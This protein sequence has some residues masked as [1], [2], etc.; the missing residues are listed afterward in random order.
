MQLAR[1][2][3]WVAV[4]ALEERAT[5]TA[6]HNK[7][8]PMS[9]LKIAVALFSASLS[10]VPQTAPAQGQPNPAELIAAQREAMQVLARMDGVWR[11]PAWTMLPNGEKHHLTQTERI[12][13]LLDGSIKVVEGRGYEAD[14]RTSFNAFGVISFNPATR[15]YSMRSHAQGRYGEFALKPTEDGYSW[16]IPAGPMTIRYVATIKDGVLK[17]VGDRVM[18]GKDPVRFFEMTLTRLGD[19]A[20]PGAGAVPPK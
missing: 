4:T 14:G 9:R 17:E 3:M 12:G 5:M 13:P 2:E 1:D 8:S 6:I 11:G 18:P 19:S 10:V 15:A 7:E 20:W 16:E